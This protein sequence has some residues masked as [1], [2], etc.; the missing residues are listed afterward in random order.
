MK[1]TKTFF[2]RCLIGTALALTVMVY[3]LMFHK[4]TLDWY[5]TVPLGPLFRYLACAALS[6]LDG[7]LLCGLLYAAFLASRRDVRDGHRR[8]YRRF[9]WELPAWFLWLGLSWVQVHFLTPAVQRPVY[10]MQF[11]SGFKSGVYAEAVH[12]E[13]LS[14]FMDYLDQWGVSSTTPRLRR[15]MDEAGQA[16]DAGDIDAEK[17][18]EY[19]RREYEK[20]VP[21]SDWMLFYPLA[22]L[23]GALEGMGARWQKK[24]REAS[25]SPV[26][27]R[28]Q[29]MRRR[30]VRVAGCGVGVLLALCYQLDVRH[31][32]KVRVQPFDPA[33]VLYADRERGR[34]LAARFFWRLSCSSRSLQPVSLR[35]CIYGRE[36]WEKSLGKL[37]GTQA[38]LFVE[39]A[40]SLRW[41]DE[42]KDGRIASFQTADYVVRADY[43]LHRDSAVQALF[44]PYVGQMRQRGQDTLHLSLSQLGALADSLLSGDEL[45]PVFRY[46]GDKTGGVS[47][48]LGE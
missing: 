10:E 36:E 30:W 35:H 45:S 16:V 29:W 47:F 1:E 33:V 5:L 17:T 23:A 46:H 14:D 11:L 6:L 31:W 37:N 22:L 8:W 21:H 48:P 18:L 44:A 25:V 40:D 38:L 3:L 39:E 15:L 26:R 20:R 41:F 13:Y 4:A 19:L 42:Q 27:P 34:A 43:R 28:G 7:A 32:V 9:A 24:R 2:K 12:S